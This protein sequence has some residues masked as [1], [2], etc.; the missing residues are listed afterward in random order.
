M[1]STLRAWLPK[2][3]QHDSR[4]L[5]KFTRSVVKRL[6]RRCA[7]CR[8]ASFVFAGRGMSCLLSRSASS[9]KVQRV[10]RLDRHP[11]HP[12]GCS[13]QVGVMELYSIEYS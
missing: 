13:T 5:G 8:E 1:R 2:M 3:L 9:T 10:L 11:A 7:A 4:S 12:G 6:M